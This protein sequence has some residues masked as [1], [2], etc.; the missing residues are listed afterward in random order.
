M[1]IENKGVCSGQAFRLFGTVKVSCL[2]LCASIFSRTAEVMEAT[3]VRGAASQS[4]IRQEC[5]HRV[6]VSGEDVF[7]LLRIPMFRQL[8][9]SQEPLC[10]APGCRTSV[11]LL[12]PGAPL[13]RERIALRFFSQATAR[14]TRSHRECFHARLTQWSR[15]TDRKTGRAPG[16]RILSS[17]RSIPAICRNLSFLRC[18]SAIRARAVSSGS[19]V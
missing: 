5:V 13:L 14:E 17:C 12:R 4:G 1:F 9:F 6:Q 11:R 2:Q 18:F 16:Q 10:S 19:W 15:Q 8:V 7:V 3:P